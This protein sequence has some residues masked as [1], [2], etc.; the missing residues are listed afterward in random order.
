MDDVLH[1]RRTL[2]VGIA[3][4][5]A[6][7]GLAGTAEAALEPG[8]ARGHHG[9]AGQQAPQKKAHGQHSKGKSQSKGKSR[10]APHGPRGD[11]SP[12]GPKEGKRG[13]PDHAGQGGDRGAE[14]EGR[15]G[16]P[17]GNNG[18]VKITPIGEADG[19]PQNTPHASCGFDVEWYGFDQGDGIVSEVVFESWAPTAVPMS[20]DGPSEV[21]VGGDPASGAGTDSGFDGEATYS[22]SFDGEPHPQ[23]GYHVKLTIHTPGS[24]GADTK[25]KVYWVAPCEQ[26]TQPE[27]L[28][29]QQTSPD[30]EDEADV[31]GEQ[32]T[33]PEAPDVLGEQET[34]PDEEQV[35]V[36]GVQ[37]TQGVPSAVAAGIG[38]AERL[39]SGLALILMLLGG[40]A[41]AAG[42]ALRRR[43]S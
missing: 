36:L 3:L 5:V 4:A 22:L 30:G 1:L 39:G 42:I 11:R 41:T 25:H 34:A 19:I 43:T 14:K 18:T 38:A 12:R 13:K 24:Q 8:K 40:L 9:K 29:E 31:L 35:E 37:A 2:A 15:T 6:T 17:P 7:L 16:D 28:G 33:A 21:F 10:G 27:L 32:A 23:Q 20:V 26:D